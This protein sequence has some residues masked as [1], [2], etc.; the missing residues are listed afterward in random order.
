MY[1][2]RLPVGTFCDARFKYGTAA[3]YSFTN[4]IKGPVVKAG[5]N[6]TKFIDPRTYGLY[7]ICASNSDLM[8]CLEFQTQSFPHCN[9]TSNEK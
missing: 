1:I 5:Q 7:C 9:Q 2:D 8:F 4:K 3:I 6:E